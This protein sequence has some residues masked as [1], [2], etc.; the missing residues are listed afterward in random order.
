MIFLILF[1]VDL[2]LRGTDDN[3]KKKIAGLYQK[4]WWFGNQSIAVII[5]PHFFSLKH[6]GFL[7]KIVLVEG[8]EPS[9]VGVRW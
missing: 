8:L 5:L 2:V 4:L 9:W 1:I 7:G 6:S 3:N